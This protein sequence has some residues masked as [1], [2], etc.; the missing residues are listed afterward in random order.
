MLIAAGAAGL[1]AIV[2]IGALTLRGGSHQQP[3]SSQQSVN[4]IDNFGP[5]PTAATSA[6]AASDQTAVANET[7]NAAPAA[8]APQPS[9]QANSTQALAAEKAKTAAA[10]A[11]IDAMKKAQAKSA[12]AQTA[13]GNAAA[14][15]SK[16]KSSKSSAAA[17]ITATPDVGVS[18][19]TLSQ[20][21]S[22]IDDARSMAKQVMRSRNSQSA[23]LARNY[24]SYLKTLKA[25]MGGIHTEKEAQKLLKQA[26]QTR[27]YIV[28]LQRQPASQ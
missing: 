17:E 23:S 5:A 4:G 12:A 24:D 7:A 15:A 18:P 28:F 13:L 8:A 26:N 10:Q 25:S 11:Q 14:K 16:A 3:A 20:F 27:A 21:N 9:E 6:E 1:L 2:G 19:A 22:T